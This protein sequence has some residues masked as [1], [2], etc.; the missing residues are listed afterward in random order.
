MTDE[1]LRVRLAEYG[2]KAHHAMKREKLLELL[3]EAEGK[4]E[5]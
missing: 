1:Q 5:A 3:A 4:K 2:V